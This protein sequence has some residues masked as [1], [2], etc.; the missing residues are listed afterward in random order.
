MLELDYL[1]RLL[2]SDA[3][4]AHFAPETTGVSVPHI[5]PEQIR[6]F[7]IPLPPLSEQRSIVAFLR[8]ETGRIDRLI[9]E[10]KTAIPLLHERRSALISAAVIG[11]ID[12]RNVVVLEAV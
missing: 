4:A 10:A 9:D 8:H 11:Q 6:A 1:E 7:V 3:F 12:V 5:S 2:S